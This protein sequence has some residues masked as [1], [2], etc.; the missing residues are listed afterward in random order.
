MIRKNTDRGGKLAPVSDNIL[1]GMKKKKRRD[2]IFAYAVL[3]FPVL[4]FLVFWLCMNV[5]TVFLSFRSGNM[6]VGEWNNFRNYAGAF[7]AIFGIDKNDGMIMNWRAL[8]NTLSLIPLSMLINLPITLIFSFAIFRK[9]KGYPIYQV[10]LFLPAMISATVLCFVF[11]MFING[12]QAV[13][14]KLLETIH[15]EKIIPTTLWLGDKR[16]AWPSMLI[17]SVWTGISTNIIYFGSSMA[18]VPESIIESVQLDGASEMT[19]FNKIV[20]PI[21]M[22][23]VCT[24]SISIVSGCFA[25]YMPSLLIDSNNQYITSLALIVIANTK[26]NNIGLASAWGVII[27]VLGMIFITVFRKITGR[28]SEE[29]EF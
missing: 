25:W 23:T 18:R 10:V 11:K 15:L 5:S 19:I 16:T 12:N 20:L 13:F 14:N 28:F 24:M 7:R 26:S 3:I 27:G 2:I 22:P 1:N 29:V 4:H 21:L 17:F 9:I 6:Q 8:L